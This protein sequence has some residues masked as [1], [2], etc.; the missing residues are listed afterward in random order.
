VIGD[1]VNLA[2]RLESLTKFYGTHILICKATYKK[3]ADRFVC[4]EI[5]SIKVK[6]KQ[7]SETIYTIEKKLDVSPTKKE[8]YF[9]DL[10]H[11]GLKKYRQR[12]F[13]KAIDFFEK[14]LLCFSNDKPTQI[15][16]K[17][18]QDFKLSPP[19]NDWTGTWT[20]SQ[21]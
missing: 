15:L 11:S 14:A 17:R 5:D 4:R 18:C 10:Y 1:A 20:F 19:T 9:I 12:K 2:S 13:G 7:I 3:I 8:K 16:L 6:G 21:K